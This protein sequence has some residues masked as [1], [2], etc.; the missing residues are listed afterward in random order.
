MQHDVAGETGLIGR[1]RRSNPQE[2][3][4]QKDREVEVK[5]WREIAA[6]F[7]LNAIHRRGR[8]M[9]EALR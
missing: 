2:P 9:A 7:K 3:L 5:I 6:A 4:R 1:R 8:L